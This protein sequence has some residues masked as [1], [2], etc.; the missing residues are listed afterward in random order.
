MDIENFLKLLQEDFSVS[1]NKSVEETILQAKRY[2][3]QD[4][5]SLEDIKLLH[6]FLQ[7]NRPLAFQRLTDIFMHNNWRQLANFTLISVQVFNRRRTGEIERIS[8]D[9]YKH[10]EDINAQTNPDLYKSLSPETQE[11]CL[12]LV[13]LICI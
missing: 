5:P 13:F 6:N 9:D 12:C 1:V 4:L 3:L 11:V 2:K 7:T 8:I 10:Q